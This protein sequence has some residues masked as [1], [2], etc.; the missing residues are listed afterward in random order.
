MLDDESPTVLSA[1]VVFS[2]NS[3]PLFV[4]TGCASKGTKKE[5]WI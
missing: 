4:D 2:S 3:V 5:T 1:A